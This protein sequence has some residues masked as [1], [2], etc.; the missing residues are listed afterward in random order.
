ML[1]LLFFKGDV[2]RDLTPQRAARLEL[3]NH[4]RK[5]GLGLVEIRKLII[6][7]GYLSKDAQTALG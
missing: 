6:A 3:V 1:K 7:C 5:S 4:L 2:M